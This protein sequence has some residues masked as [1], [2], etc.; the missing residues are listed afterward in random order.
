VPS[1]PL[2]NALFR[3]AARQRL[4]C[5][6]AGTCDPVHDAE[7]RAFDRMLV[8]VPEHTWGVAQSWFL[9]ES[10]GRD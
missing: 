8:K 9:P 7:V 6:H 2:K 10:V 1:D 5:I 3:E 4:S